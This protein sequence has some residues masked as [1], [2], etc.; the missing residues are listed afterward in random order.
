MV[1]HTPGPWYAVGSWVEHANDEVPDIC[2]CDPAGM[3]QGHLGRSKAEIAA[4]ARLIAAAP[5]M[6][7]AAIPALAIIEVFE[8]TFGVTLKE[9]DLLRAAIAKAKG[10]KA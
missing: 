1:K 3:D 6:L 10:K 7:S 4:N 9:G 5:D 2:Y 8:T